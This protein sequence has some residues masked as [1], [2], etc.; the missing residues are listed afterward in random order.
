MTSHLLTPFEMAYLLECQRILT[1]KCDEKDNHRDSE[2]TEKRQYT[3]EMRGNGGTACWLHIDD[4]CHPEQCVDVAV[5]RIDATSR[6]G[7]VRTQ[8]AGNHCCK[9]TNSGRNFCGT[10]NSSPNK[11]VNREIAIKNN[12]CICCHIN[13]FGTVII[14]GKR[15]SDL[16]LSGPVN[17]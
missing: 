2:R 11:G 5:V 17:L 9:R 8:T 13:A 12:S 4:S 15:N 3:V 14:V 16:R 6:H 10:R 7:E 1:V